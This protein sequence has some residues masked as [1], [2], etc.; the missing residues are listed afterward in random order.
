MVVAWVFGS[1]GFHVTSKDAELSYKLGYL[2]MAAL[3]CPVSPLH[4]VSPGCQ[5]LFVP[6]S[7]VYL[8]QP[9]YELPIP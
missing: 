7:K 1:A 8:H 2:I 3:F 4:P 9:H 5:C 6:I